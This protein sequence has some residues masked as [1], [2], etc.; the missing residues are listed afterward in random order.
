MQIGNAS[1][2]PSPTQAY[3]SVPV[4]KPADQDPNQ[5]DNSS[6]KPVAAPTPGSPSHASAE[7][8]THKT[9]ETNASKD[10]PRDNTT[11]NSDST[12][13]SGG[14]ERTQQDIAKQLAAEHV[15]QEQ[16]KQERIK[17]EKAEEEHRKEARKAEYQAEDHKAHAMQHQQEQQ[18]KL[19]QQ[20]KLAAQHAA[21]ERFAEIR[22]RTQ[23][24]TEHHLAAL[25]KLGTQRTPHIDQNA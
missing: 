25:E 1:P 18:E 16:L 12:R 6:F 22:S 11:E 15:R 2:P 7:P 23:G 19:Q 10:M 9:P 14:D 24:F 17:Q 21:A 8:V 3:A 20:K 13:E 4:A 5:L